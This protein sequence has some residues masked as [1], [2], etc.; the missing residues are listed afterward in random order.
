MVEEDTTGQ[1][2]PTTHTSGL[3]QK[4][5][6]ADPSPSL[7]TLQ[8]ATSARE[9]LRETGFL[10]AHDVSGQA[11]PGQQPA[12]ILL[13]GAGPFLA[14]LSVVSVPGP[15]VPHLLGNTRPLAVPTFGALRLW[16]WWRVALG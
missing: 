4:A 10:R 2:P 8:R 5:R 6:V 12:L 15:L 3:D 16:H 13:K 7:A 9:P 14:T 11:A 1:G